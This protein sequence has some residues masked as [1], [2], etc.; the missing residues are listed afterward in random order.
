M[1]LPAI[2]LYGGDWMRDNVAGCGLSSQGLWLRMMFV[3][4]DAK[5]Y[6]HLIEN[7]APMKPDAA[8]RRCGAV[9]KEYARFLA[10]LVAAGV[11]RFTGT[12]EYAELLSATLEKKNRETVTVDL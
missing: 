10:E 9:P 11:P 4:H 5:P 1:R 12:T 3:M 6:G 8:A 7:G 2:H